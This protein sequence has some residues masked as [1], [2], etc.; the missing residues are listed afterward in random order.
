MK[1]LAALSMLLASLAVGQ[2]LAAHPLP[3]TGSFQDSPFVI[4]DLTVSDKIY[5]VAFYHATDRAGILTTRAVVV[6]TPWGVYGTA[7]EAFDDVQLPADALRLD[8]HPTRQ[9]IWLLSFK[10]TLPN[11]GEWDL[12]FGGLLAS[13]SSYPEYCL[14]TFWMAIGSTTNH[15]L[16]TY[17]SSVAGDSNIGSW[18][19]TWGNGGAVAFAFR[20]VR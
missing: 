9:G 16:P 18:C 3:L 10:A 14:E 4:G 17:A 15:N 5:R 1:K 8:P 20:P 2:N 12:H 13:Q 11:T 19:S 7:P 6:R